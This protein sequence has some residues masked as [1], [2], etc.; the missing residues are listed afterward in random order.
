[1]LIKMVARLRYIQYYQGTLKHSNEE[2]E[3]VPTFSF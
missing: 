2:C 3:Y 1:M